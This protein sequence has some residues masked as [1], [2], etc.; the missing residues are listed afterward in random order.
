MAMGKNNKY[1]RT[2]REMCF[3]SSPKLFKPLDMMKFMT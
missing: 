3:V 2:E 1:A